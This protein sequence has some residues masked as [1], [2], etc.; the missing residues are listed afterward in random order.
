MYA[1]KQKGIS[2]LFP[3]V[4]TIIA[5]HKHGITLSSMGSCNMVSRIHVHCVCMISLICSSII[6][7]HRRF[8]F[9]MKDYYS[10]NS[11]PPLY[12]RHHTVGK[13]ETYHTIISCIAKRTP[14]VNIEVGRRLV[15]LN[16]ITLL[17]M[18]FINSAQLIKQSA[19]TSFIR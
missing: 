17:K 16:V 8:C 6:G 18:Q 15:C 12:V 19:G 13:I 11:C 5:I 4:S 14:K 3:N 1:F 10:T 2:C 9:M 7:L